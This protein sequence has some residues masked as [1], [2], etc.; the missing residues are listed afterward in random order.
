MFSVSGATLITGFQTGSG[1][2]GFSQKGH[3]TLHLAICC[4]TFARLPHFVI[5]NILQWLITFCKFAHNLPTKVHLRRARSVLTSSQT[6]VCSAVVIS[7]SLSLSLRRHRLKGYWAQRVPSLFFLQAVPG[8]VCLSYAALRCTLTWRTRYPLS[9]CWR[10]NT[11]ILYVY[12]HIHIHIYI[13]IY[14][15][16]ILYI[17]I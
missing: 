7:L 5:C 12:I 11:H 6:C 13:Y 14:I 2:T 3:K 8:Q 17:Y 16:I 1:Q 4:F 15:F 10:E 9:R